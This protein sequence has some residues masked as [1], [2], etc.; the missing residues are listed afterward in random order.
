MARAETRLSER[1]EKDTLDYR[2]VTLVGV[3]TL[4]FLLAALAMLLLAWW[5]MLGPR[6]APRPVPFG[7]TALQ[8]EERIDLNLYLAAQRAELRGY[9]W[10]D[11][12]RGLVRIPIERAMEI[13][14]GRGA[15]GWAPLAPMPSREQTAP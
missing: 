4:G 5:L 1:R 8:S 15:A 14:G 12:E 2:V 3:G 7:P 13:V 6:E 11:R 10:V 9:A